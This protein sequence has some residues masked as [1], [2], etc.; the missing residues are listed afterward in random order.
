MSRQ[1]IKMIESERNWLLFLKKKGIYDNPVY[2]LCMTKGN[3]L[4]NLHNISIFL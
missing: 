3:I 1:E 4:V 2:V